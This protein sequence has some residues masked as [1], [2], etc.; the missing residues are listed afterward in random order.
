MD[1]HTRLHFLKH[2]S[3]AILVLKAFVAFIQ[4]QYS[5]IIKVIRSN[6]L[7]EM[8]SSNEARE[9]IQTKGILH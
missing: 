3:Y 6:N 7:Y 9:F 5:K 4:T 2:K 1:H 8:G